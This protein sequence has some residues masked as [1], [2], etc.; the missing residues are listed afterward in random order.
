MK[1]FLLSL[2]IIFL[3]YFIAYHTSGASEKQDLFEIGNFPFMYK[4][5]CAITGE[6]D[7]TDANELYYRA[8]MYMDTE[9]YELA[10]KDYKK[11]IELDPGIVYVR[12]DLASAYLAIN[13][14]LSAIS[15]YRRDVIDSDFPEKAYLELG[16][17]YQ[18]MGLL[19]SSEY[20]YTKAVESDPEHHEASYH[21]A[22]FYFNTKRYDESL[23]YVNK[24]IDGNQYDL[25]YKNLR[26]KIYV[27][28]ENYK[29]AEVDYQYISSNDPYY[30]GNYKEI[31]KEARDEGKYQLAVENYNLALEIKPKDVELLNE[32]GLAY[33]NLLKYDSALMDFKRAE[34]ISPDY[35]TFFNIAYTLDLLG[36][37]K[38]S[39]EYYNKSIEL[40]SDYF[41]SYNNRGT[42][43]FRLKKYAKAVKDYT[44]SIELKDDYY[45]GYHNRGLTYFKLKKYKKAISDYKKAMKLT[46]DTAIIVYDLAL[47]YEKIKNKSKAIF[48]FNEYLKSAGTSDTARVNSAIEKVAKLSK[49]KR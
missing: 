48:Y 2:F 49:K 13:D 36:N 45:L 4:I 43:Y 5:K 21:F 34:E 29:L 12:I 25:N 20:F 40:K 39:V 35:Y 11:V 3:A 18:K 47:V 19:D 42:G 27:K 32:R 31:A 46:D 41:Y 17:L 15:Q 44:I 7:T 24:A 14:T 22:F 23:N 30:F 16:F 8:S 33:Q 26:R 6:T 28:L 37:I 10:I 9:E 38:E 1:K